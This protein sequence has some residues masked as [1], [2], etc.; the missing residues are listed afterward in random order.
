M[1]V[2]LGRLTLNFL[3]LTVL[4]ASALKGAE[5]PPIE[6][7]IK[8]AR[9]AHEACREGK[10]RSIDQLLEKGISAPRGGSPE[11]ECYDVTYY[12]LKMKFDRATETIY[13]D[14][15][16]TADV[17]APVS[18]CILDC[19]WMMRV[20]SVTVNGVR[21]GFVPN[22]LVLPVTL[23]H[24][25]QPGERFTV[26]VFYHGFEP[27]FNWWALHFV[28]YDGK[29]VVGNLSETWYARAW[30]PCKDY[31]ND[32]A[33]SLDFFITYPSNQFCSSNGTM[34]SDVDNLDGFRTTHWSAR[35]PIATYLVSVAMAEFTHWREW[36]L[37]TETDSLPV[38]YW[39]YPSLVPSVQY[40][41]SFTVPAIDILSQLFGVYPFM[42]EK[43]AMSNFMWGG[44]M[45]H[46]TN[47]S[48]SPGLAQSVMTMV[49]ELAHQWWGD[50]ITCRDWHHSWLNEGFATYSEALFIEAYLG[51]E[52]LYDY[53]RGIRYYGDD[54]VYRY[55]TSDTWIILDNI[56]YDKGAWVLHMLRGVIGDQAFFTGLRAYGDS[57]LKYGTAVT[58][59]LQ[60][61]META[62]GTDLD[63]FFSEWIYG[64]G[65]PQY[66]YSWQCVPN[67]AGGYGVDL[68][69]RQVQP[70]YG[71]FKM[72]VQ[73]QFLTANGATMDTIWNQ[74]GLA[75]YQFEFS[76]SVTALNFDPDNWILKTAAETPM[77]LTIVTRVLPNGV[78][79]RPYHYDLQA[80][81]GAAPYTWTFLGGDVPIG[82]EF[83]GGNQAVL[84]G[85]PTYAA[86]YYFTLK[87]EDAGSTP[88]TDMISLVLTIEPGR[89]FGDCNADDE[90][91]IVDVVY[92]LNYIF[93]G[94][95]APVPTDTGD[96]NCNG[97]VNISDAVYLI[98]Y[99][100]LNGAAPCW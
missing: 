71:A 7:I 26:R 52:A 91:N 68:I 54:A 23:D 60:G 72:P 44:A 75:Y 24:L 76:D 10:S 48:M 17:V 84:S 81:G 85:I 15:S 22:Y 62:S 39:V 74:S 59:D 99:M 38:D 43:Y 65:N 73:I 90:I 34:V 67:G 94:G 89:H 12:N 36:A 51:R 87:V 49:H 58:E 98:N 53:M 3:V 69:V 64:P 31:P 8:D 77:A 88:R 83:T 30:W 27:E 45:E 78:E 18:Q 32:K 21:A 14:V 25:Y 1:W 40:A 16:M 5:L 56:V 92:L 93:S 50:M 42:D 2:I 35:Y 95:P 79:G 41:Y 33:D 55:D 82:I 20:D 57:P 66:L 46:Q 4:T 86:S 29:P 37:R 63:W 11:Q 97:M 13:G 47:T 19:Y 61:Y 9:V 100:F 28:E 80:V 96:A 70:D 6:D